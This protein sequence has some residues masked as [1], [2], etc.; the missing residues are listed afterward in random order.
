MPT[1]AFPTSWRF[2]MRGI[3]RAA[4]AVGVL[5]SSAAFGLHAQARVVIGLGGGLALPIP[6]SKF[7]GVEHDGDVSV[8]SLGFGGMLYLGVVP[9]PDSKINIRFDVAY[10]N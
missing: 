9:K 8:K 5:L 7:N 4:T 2:S 3:L 10:D 6:K 1:P